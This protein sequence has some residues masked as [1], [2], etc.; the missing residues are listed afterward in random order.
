M[1]LCHRV[2]VTATSMTTVKE[3]KTKRK[4]WTMEV[5]NYCRVIG[6]MA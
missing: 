5:T 4:M 1:V 3:M 2:P 6:I